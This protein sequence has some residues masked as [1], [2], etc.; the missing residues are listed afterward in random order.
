MR[1]RWFVGMAM[2]G[3]GVIAASWGAFDIV[4][5]GECGGEGTPPCPPEALA[6]I[7]A[8]VVGLFGAILGAIFSR[9]GRLLTAL[10]GLILTTGALAVYLSLNGPGAEPGVDAGP[11]GQT[12]PAM[13]GAIGAAILLLAAKPKPPVWTVGHGG[14]SSHWGSGDYSDWGGSDSGG[15]SGCSSGCGGGC[16]GGGD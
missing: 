4:Q 10:F 7:G 9:S 3:G 6:P 1:F 15:D 13:L 14:G 12:I 11:L 16:G 8:L 5:I 2:V